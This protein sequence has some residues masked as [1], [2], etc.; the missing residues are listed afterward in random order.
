MEIWKVLRKSGNLIITEFNEKEVEFSSKDA[1][2]LQ[3]AYAITIH[4]SQGSD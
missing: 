2:D 4:L 3:L 1:F